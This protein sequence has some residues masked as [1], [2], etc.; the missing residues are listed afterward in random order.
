[1]REVPGTV[2]GQREVGDVRNLVR[3]VGD[4][5]SSLDSRV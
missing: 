3:K 5:S 2:E 4:A 1:M